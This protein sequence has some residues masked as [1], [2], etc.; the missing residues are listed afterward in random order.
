M[1]TVEEY[2]EEWYVAGLK[3]FIR[4]PNLSI[5]Y[6]P[7]YQT[8]G[9][10][11]QAMECV[12]EYA[13]R[14]GIEGLSRQVFKGEGQ[15]PL[16]VYVV[17]PCAGQTKNVMFYGHLDKQP[18]DEPWSEGLSPTEPVIKDGRMY[19]RGS[20]DDGYAAFSCLL[21]VKAAQV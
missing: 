19:G 7:D 21:A 2:W 6:D 8:N 18:Y 3:D 13:N 1:Q 5:L 16:I 17:E 10:L 15:N 9:L 11:E 12:D 14:L 20:S 4:I